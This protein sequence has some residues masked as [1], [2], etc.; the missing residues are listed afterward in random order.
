MD[1]ERLTRDVP[2]VA[3]RDVGYAYVTAGAVTQALAG[4]SLEVPRGGTV[5]FVGP[6]GCG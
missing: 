1:D 4:V 3:L 5:A 2:A 6:S